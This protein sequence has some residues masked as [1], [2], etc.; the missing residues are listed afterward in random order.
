MR[1]IHTVRMSCL[2]HITGILRLALV[3]SRKQV[4]PA[5]RRRHGRRRL[6]ADVVAV[7]TAVA[8]AAAVA[9]AV[10]VAAAD[11][12]AA[13]APGSDSLRGRRLRV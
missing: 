2:G 12:D 9:V 10:A 7:A 11:A 6:K 3:S 13:A 4:R 5:K 1:T 8:A